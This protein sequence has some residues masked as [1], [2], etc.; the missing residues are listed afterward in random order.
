MS[1]V[2]APLV[3]LEAKPVPVLVH[4]LEQVL[5]RE[6]EREP[7][8]VLASARGMEAPPPPP[9]PSLDHRSHALCCP[10]DD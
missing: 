6:R 8:L 2:A 4:E 5:E 10:A 9:A 1:E 7:E 3:L